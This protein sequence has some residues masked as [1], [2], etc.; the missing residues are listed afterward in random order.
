MSFG[1]AT[2]LKATDVMG[3]LTKSVLVFGCLSLYTINLNY[4][5]EL[6]TLS[7]K[8]MFYNLVCS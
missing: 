5:Y 4:L 3:I 8:S 1:F 7:T 6:I 2:V